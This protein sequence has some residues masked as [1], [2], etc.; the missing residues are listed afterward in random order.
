VPSRGAADEGA[1]AA[2]GDYQ[3]WL[4]IRAQPTA[5]QC[6]YHATKHAITGLTKSISLDAGRT[7]LPATDRYRNAGTPDQRMSDGVPQRTGG[8]W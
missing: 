2:G 1:N 6:G 8:G 3:Q 4:D 7:E 5:G